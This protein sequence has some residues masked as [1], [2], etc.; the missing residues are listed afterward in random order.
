MSFLTTKHASGMI[1]LV[2]LGLVARLG[3][4]VAE[5]GGIDNY[6]NPA[7]AV[8]QELMAELGKFPGNGVLIAQ[9]QAD[10]PDEYKDFVSKVGKAARGTG[11]DTRVLVVANTWLNTFLAAHAR[12][13][14]GAPLPALDAVLAAE[15]TYL[16]GLQD[17]D[18]IVCGAVATGAPLDKPLTAALEEQAGAL[19]AS[20]FAAIK[21]GRTD[22][23]LRCAITPKDREALAGDLKQ[24]GLVEDQM[25][26][27]SGEVDPSSISGELACEAAVTLNEAIRAQPDSRRALLIGAKLGGV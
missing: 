1:G 16:A 4:G 25:K 12:D 15:Q 9:L 24:R 14:A 21:A 27:L 22:Q 7:G 17:Y 2:V 3:F 23:Q 10:F 13:F 26:V 18:P 5:A 6:F 8:D 19:V 20:K 11:P